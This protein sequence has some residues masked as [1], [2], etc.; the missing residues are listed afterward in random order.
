MQ[1]CEELCHEGVCVEHGAVEHTGVD[2]VAA[3]ACTSMSPDATPRRLVVSVVR[4][5]ASWRSLRR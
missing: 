4:R 2:G 3:D 5:R 1:G